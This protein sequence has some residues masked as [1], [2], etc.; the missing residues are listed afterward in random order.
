MSFAKSKALSGRN[1]GGMYLNSLAA[2]P[3]SSLVDWREEMESAHGYSWLT[4]TE[5]DEV[6]GRKR[7]VRALERAGGDTEDLAMLLRLRRVLRPM[8]RA[9][10]VRYVAPMVAR[11]R[12]RPLKIVTFLCPIPTP[13]RTDIAEVDDLDQRRINELIETM[14]SMFVGL[15][16]RIELWV[17]YVYDSQVLGTEVETMIFPGI[18]NRSDAAAR[19]DHNFALSKQVVDRLAEALNFP[20]EAKSMIEAIG[21]APATIKNLQG[22]GLMD[23]PVRKILANPPASY[24]LLDPKQRQTLARTDVGVYLHTTIKYG[25]GEWLC[26]G[27]EVHDGY[28]KAD[29]L[30]QFGDHFFP[31]LFAPDRLR[32]HWTSWFT[33]EIEERRRGR[34]PWSFR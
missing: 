4:S 26:L 2:G 19:L 18:R 20:I 13:R 33:R 8:D 6:K 3:L 5:A 15:D 9:T 7:E 29:K 22:Q 32:G 34:D 27:L 21:D 17:F 23:G 25:K 16:G 12:E 31:V 11:T 10:V 28:W 14:C 1:K 24:A 30:W